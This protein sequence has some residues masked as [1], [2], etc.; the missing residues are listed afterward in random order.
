MQ[1]P[2]LSL[3]DQRLHEQKLWGTEA[4]NNYYSPENSGKLLTRFKLLLNELNYEGFDELTA[5]N[6]IASYLKA[7]HGLILEQMETICG[8]N[9]HTNFRYCLTVPTIWSDRTK[10]SMR[11]A[12][13]GAGIIKSHDHPCRLMLVNEPEAAAMFYSNDPLLV[14]EFPNK[15]R[16]RALVCDAGGGTVDM[17]TYE[18]FKQDKDKDY[19]IDEVTPGSGGICGASFLDDKFRQLISKKCYDMDYILEEHVLEQMVNQFATKIKVGDLVYYRDQNEMLI[20]CCF[21]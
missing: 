17:A 1:I 20:Y 14:K 5:V 6:A 3:Y 7:L 16:I 10:K 4:Y 12:A 13:V 21:S 8:G 2:T 15:K 11:D 9:Q 18:L 19:S